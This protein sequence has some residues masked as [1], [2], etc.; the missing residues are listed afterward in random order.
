MPKTT[1]N[2]LKLI[3][4]S[5]KGKTGSLLSYKNTQFHRV[6]PG[7]A[8]QGGDVVKKD[9]TGGGESIYGEK[10]NDESFAVLHEKEGILTMV[11]N[12][13]NTNQS[14]FLIT[15]GPSTWFFNIFFFFI[16]PFFCITLHIN[17]NKFINIKI[18]SQFFKSAS[19]FTNKLIIMS[20]KSL[21]F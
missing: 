10:F 8:I 14:Q 4:G 18:F 2:F 19:R 16:C 7:F 20:L 17:N 11:N 15:L 1:E 3:L 6:F 13:P 21:R 12:G 9:G 5:Y